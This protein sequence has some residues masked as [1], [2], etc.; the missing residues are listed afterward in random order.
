M[1]QR[2]FSFCRYVWVH[3]YMYQFFFSQILHKTRVRESVEGGMVHDMGEKV[4]I[5]MCSVNPDRDWQPTAYIILHCS[6]SDQSHHESRP[7]Y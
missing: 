2:G 4:K 5:I 3:A 1:P 7:N 6:A